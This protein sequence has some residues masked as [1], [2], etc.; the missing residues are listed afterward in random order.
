MPL[1]DRVEGHRR[2]IGTL[3][4]PHHLGTHPGPPRLQ[5]VGGRGPERVGGAQHDAPAVGDQDPGQ[6]SHGGGLAR[7]VDP[8]HQQHRRLV[9]MRQRLDRAVEL[10]V[11][12]VDQRLAQHQAGVGLGAHTAGRQ[13]AAQM[14]HHRRRD[15]R[16]EVGHQEHVLDLLP[17]LLVQ[18][19]AAEQAEHALAERV[20]GLRQPAAQPLEAALDGCDGVE[21]GAA[22]TGTSDRF[23]DRLRQ[24]VLNSGSGSRRSEIGRLGASRGMVASSP[25]VGSPSKVVVSGVTRGGAGAAFAGADWL[26]VIPE[27]AV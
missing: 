14:A 20:L 27:D 4:A 15:G 13:T 19:A 10:G 6:L 26:N 8:D 16:S 3:G 23:G 17:R 2:G 18:I 25:T 1:V 11:Q 7:A 5:L 21:F 9:D 12:F 24:G 22:G